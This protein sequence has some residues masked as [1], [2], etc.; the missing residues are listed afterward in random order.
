MKR[1]YHRQQAKAKALCECN[2]WT[3]ETRPAGTV[4]DIHA[5]EKRAFREQPMSDLCTPWRKTWA[6][7]CE[8]KLAQPAR[9]EKKL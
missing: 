4:R 2:G 3:T 6:E 8:D 1:D 7:V 5:T 9:R